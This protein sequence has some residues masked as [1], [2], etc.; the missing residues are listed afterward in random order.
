MKKFLFVMFPQARAVVTHG[1]HGTVMKALAHGVPLL[2][3]PLG[4]DQADNAVRVVEAGAG[5][6]V[7]ATA[8]TAA[9][10]RALARLLAEPAFAESARRMADEIAR[11]VA[12]D[13]ATRELEALAGA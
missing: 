7:K 12:A 5:L 1:G 13:R 11:D 3:V 6:R 10:R 8:R 4:R 2:S 9:L